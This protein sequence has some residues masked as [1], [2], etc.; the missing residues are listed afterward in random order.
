MR[1]RPAAPHASIGVS[2]DAVEFSISLQDDFAGNRGP[3]VPHVTC[4]CLFW[5][6]NIVASNSGYPTFRQ[7]DLCIF[8]NLDIKDVSALILGKFL[9]EGPMVI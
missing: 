5:I 3:T 2:F 4:F 1:E 8:Q 7:S 6:C 9:I